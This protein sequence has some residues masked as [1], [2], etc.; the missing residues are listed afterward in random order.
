M[1]RIILGLFI[2]SLPTLL[3]AEEGL[4]IQK[5]IRDVIREKVHTQCPTC[6]VEIEFIENIKASRD[7][8]IKEVHPTHLKGESIVSYKQEGQINKIP[9]S[10]RWYDQVVVAKNNII[11]G[12]TIEESDLAKVEKD[13]TFNS[14][15]YLQEPSQAI[16]M[17]GRRLFPRGQI[18]DLSQLKKPRLIKY[19]QPVNL[20]FAQGGL[21]LSM[22]GQ[23]RGAGVEGDR[24]PVIINGTKKKVMAKILSKNEV[25]VE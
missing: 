19:G 2:F 4:A 25:R 22:M 16:G 23:A 18:V 21:S 3:G 12:K 6:R 13:I 8:A 1:V 5:Q 9:V 17:V 11:H 10:I 14:I 24:I 7:E 15:A 20:S